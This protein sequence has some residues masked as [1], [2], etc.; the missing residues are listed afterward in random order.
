MRTRPLALAALLAAMPAAAQTVHTLPT[1]VITAPRGSITVPSAGAAR[2]AIEKIPG[3]AELVP[4]ERF[5]DGKATT[6]KD[7]LDYTPGVFIQPKYGQEDAKLSIRGSGLSRNFHLR[8]VRL[9]LDGVPV[10]Q[11]D[12]SGDFHEIDPL[13]QA[14]VEV[15]KGANALRYGAA[16]LGG[17]IDFVSPTGR[18]HPGLMARLYGGSFGTHGQQGAIG[19]AE[20]PWDMWATVTNSHSNGWRDHTLNDYLRFNGNLGVRLDDG[21]ESRFFVSANRIRNA[22]PGS[23]A[24]FQFQ[25]DPT[26]GPPANITQDTRRDVDSFRIANRTVFQAGDDEATLSGFAKS[27]Y[28]FHP[29]TFG[30]VDNELFDWGITGQYKG[31]REVAGLT[32]EFLIGLNFFAG[33]NRNR[34]FA[35]VFGT[36]G[37][38]TN[39][40]NETST[41]VE[42]YGESRLWVVPELALIAGLQVNWANRMLEDNFLVN[43]NDSG[44]RAYV[45]ANPRVGVLWQANREL[46]FF[47]NVSRASEPPA[48]SELNPSV[49]PGF[50]NLE[51]QKSWTV[52]IGSRGRFGER[53][54][55]D[56]SLYRAWLQDELQ[57]VLVPGFG[58]APIAA[59]IPR[60]IHQGV[61]LGLAG[62]IVEGLT[63]RLAYTFSDFRFD[64]DP[65]YGNNQL[66]GAPRHYIRAEMRYAHSSGFYIGP[67]L[68][69]VPEGYYVDNV[70]NPAFQTAPYALLGLKAGYTGFKGVEIFLDG[71]NLTDAKYV[72]NVSVINTA[73]P[74]SAL[75]N[76]GDGIG[77]FGG[78]QVRF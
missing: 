26:Q 55:W 1:T 56:V 13:A 21:I 60:S 19:I 69:W 50:A 63:G 31:A 44:A 22:I 58:A 53:L 28:L 8:G 41:S 66:P 47:A 51:P 65:I 25:S 5:R 71:R 23:L 16:S 57:L 52:E 78:V 49:A 10:N 75:Y 27:K 54:A 15:H 72:S 67:N 45:S 14:Y 40:V 11:A 32:D 18:S 2:E 43:G 38:L 20:G 59:N 64:G 7:V 35:N 4:A 76:P 24:L 30:V 34:I 70:N 77:V 29:L 42:L 6:L 36:K 48:F 61:E 12:G 39:D 17:A 46:Q 33:T 9:L 68:E 3:G 74:L 73:T 62:R 37:A